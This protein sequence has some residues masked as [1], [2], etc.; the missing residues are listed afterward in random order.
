MKVEGKEYRQ[1]ENKNV[2]YEWFSIGNN[3]KQ[4]L[5]PCY[6]T[7]NLLKDIFEILPNENPN[8]PYLTFLNQQITDST[9]ETCKH[10]YNVQQNIFQFLEV[11]KQSKKGLFG[12]LNFFASVSQYKNGLDFT[13]YGN[14]FDLQVK[15]IL[16]NTDLM[17][18]DTHNKIQLELQ[19]R[20][21]LH[22]KSKFSEKEKPY[23]DTFSSLLSECEYGSEMYIKTMQLIKPAIEN[24]YKENSHHPEHYQ[25]GINGMN[26]FDV[27]EMFCDWAAACKRNKNGNF[28]VSIAKNKE[29]FGMSEEL[30]QLFIETKDVLQW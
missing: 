8:L 24:H 15:H 28:S 9:L 29:R 2:T 30:T 21:L 7:D 13:R 27:I 5:T 12:L 16:R 14:H 10:I 6:L 20:A 25:N 17:P 18:K 11:Y 26:L 22:D 23:F 3:L 19:K 1:Y 4:S